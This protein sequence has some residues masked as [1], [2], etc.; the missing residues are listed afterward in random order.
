MDIYNNWGQG[1]PN[2]ADGNEDC[3][4]LRRDNTLNDDKCDRKYPFICKKRLIDL[5]WNTL[6]DIPD[7]GKIRF[8]TKN[9]LLVITVPIIFLQAIL[10]RSSTYII[11]ISG[12]KRP[13]LDKGPS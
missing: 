11:I 9:P 1:E 2:D 13:L 8:H 7:Q 6:C 12:V 4:I 3:V 5:D 10:I